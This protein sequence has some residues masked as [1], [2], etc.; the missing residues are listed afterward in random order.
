[1]LLPWNS[2]IRTPLLVALAAAL[3]LVSPAVGARHK[4]KS[5]ALD[6]G[7]VDINTN[8]GYQGSSAAGTGLIVT[9]S[10]E[11]VTNNHVVRGATT[12]RAVDVTTHRT[13]AATVVGYDVAQ[14]VAVLQLA[15]ASHL[16]TIQAG[17]SAKVARGLKVTALG[18]DGGAGGAPKAATGRI[19]AVGRSITAADESGATETLTGVF[20]TNA[21]VEPGDSGGALLNPAGRV[22]GMIAAGS[23][24]YG[25]QASAGDGFA[26]PI[27]RV[28]SIARQ[29]EAGNATAEIHVG[30]TAFLGVSVGDAGRYG[31]GAGALVVQ[32]V[33]GTPAEAAGLV[34]GDVITAIDGHPIAAA[35]G[36]TAAVL[37]LKPGTPVEIDWTDATGVAQTGQIT[38]ADGP[39]Q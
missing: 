37:S 7:L 12:I 23:A 32:V 6:A 22:I 25:F 1:M 39:P 8:L 30:P 5:P 27:N 3:L 19:V 4:A 29:I 9:S 21:A 24:G 18:N 20:E 33:P 35:S 13:Y 36:L 11:V 26:I 38:P 2:M 16:Q 31:G 28:L 14:D 17:N 10:G 15:N 34:R